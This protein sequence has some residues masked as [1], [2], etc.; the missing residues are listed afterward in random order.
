ML[1]IKFCSIAAFA[2]L[3][4]CGAVSAET[5]SI[6]TSGQFS[7]DVT[8]T[9]LAAPGGTF[10][11]SFDLSGTPSVANPDLTGFDAP[12]TSF[13]YELNGAKVS[14]VPQSVRF[15]TTDDLGLFTVYFGPQSGFDDNGN[16]IP[17]FSFEG[18][19]SLFRRHHQ[20]HYPGRYLPSGR[21]DLLRYL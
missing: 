21:M 19:Q 16:P 17:E 11:L 14:A 12:F 5:L 4:L 18:T 7:S 3:T 1:I 6:A 2:Y 8:P 15:S 20:P 9:Q 13:S 10:L